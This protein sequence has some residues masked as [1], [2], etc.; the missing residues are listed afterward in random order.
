MLSL[1]NALSVSNLTKDIFIAQRNKLMKNNVVAQ[2]IIPK[3]YFQIVSSLGLLLLT[4]WLTCS[5]PQA[6]YRI[7]I[8][9]PTALLTQ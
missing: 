2:Y 1:F 9:G 6:M 8:V 5:Q 7:G 4:P 3:R